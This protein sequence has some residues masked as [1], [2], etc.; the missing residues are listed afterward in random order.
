MAKH[1]MFVNISR[2]DE[3]MSFA[4][5]INKKSRKIGQSDISM[6]LVGKIIG[7][8]SQY[9]VS[10]ELPE[11]KIPGYELI[12]SIDHDTDQSGKTNFIQTNGQ[13]VV[14]EYYF[15]APSNCEHCNV[16]RKRRTTFL[17]KNEQD[18][19]IQVGSTCMKDFVGID[20]NKI[21]KKL[22]FAKS[23]TNNTDQFSES[24]YITSHRWLDREL[25]LKSILVDY[26]KNKF[27]FYT[28]QMVLGEYQRL[29]QQM[30]IIKQYPNIQQDIDIITKYFKELD[31][32]NHNDANMKAIMNS[33]FISR[34]QFVELLNHV[35]RW[36]H[37]RDYTPAPVSQHRG[38]V[39]DN[40]ELS[41]VLVVRKSEFDG[42]YG[43]T[44]MIRMKQGNDI[45]TTFTTGR[46]NPDVDSTI[47]ITGKIKKH[48]VYRGIK[49]TV[50]NYVEQITVD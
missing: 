46:F 14:P 18:Q 50:L 5:S 22:E 45:F 40:L 4:E 23:I 48:D 9:I 30:D 20:A 3:L 8:T 25:A 29:G 39:G 44:R 49:Q 35:R 21:L 10:V 33:M 11:L 28:Q 38:T 13:Q 6:R 31:S 27:T 24:S 42:N 1:T 34:G 7:K 43:R 2:I 19:Y 47:N 41:N 17:M 12:A 16:K 32:N 26:Y 37:Q 36:L 15:E